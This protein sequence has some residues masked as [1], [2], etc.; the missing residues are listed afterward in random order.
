MLRDCQDLG[1]P[2]SKFLDIDD[3]NVHYKVSAPTKSKPNPFSG[4]HMYHGFGKAITKPQSSYF[5]N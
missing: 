3:I 2:D 4:I 5:K 1:D